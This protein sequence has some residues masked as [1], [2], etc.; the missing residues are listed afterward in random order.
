MGDVATLF[1]F[2]LFNFFTPSLPSPFLGLTLGPSEKTR[3]SAL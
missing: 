1:R 3:P 2:K